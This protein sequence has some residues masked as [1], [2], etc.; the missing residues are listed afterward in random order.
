VILITSDHGESFGQH[1][2]GE[3]GG[4][5][6]PFF[7]HSVYV[8]EE[9]QHIPMILYDPQRAEPPGERGMNVSQVDVAPTLVAGTGHDPRSFG[10]TLPGRDLRSLPDDPRTVFFLTFGRGKPGL[11]KRFALDHPN[12]IGFRSGDTKFFMDQRRL[13]QGAEGECH[14]YDLGQDPDEMTNLCDRPE[15]RDRAAWYRQVVLDWWERSVA[16]GRVP[17][18]N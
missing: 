1:A 8:W 4:G 6:R 12:F 3:P 11:L 7:E 15:Q 14:L 13:L 17:A 16:P 9:T 10:A 18:A 5:G 2:V